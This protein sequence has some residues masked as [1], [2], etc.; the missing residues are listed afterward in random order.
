MFFAFSPC[1]FRRACDAVRK[2]RVISSWQVSQL[3]EPANSAPGMLGGARIARFVSNVLQESRIT[4]S[5]TIPPTPQ[6]SFSRLP[7][8]H[9]VS[10]ECH[11]DC[12]YYQKHEIVTMHFFGKICVPIF[13]IYLRFRRLSWAARYP[14]GDFP[15]SLLKTRLN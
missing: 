3:S 6:N 12:K 5:A 14:V 11:T 9:R 2:L 1:A 10:L 8:I 7:L 4:A 15:E 13:W